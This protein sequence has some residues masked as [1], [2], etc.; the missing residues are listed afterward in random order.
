MEQLRDRVSTMEV[1]LETLR[2]R[3]TQV[4]DLRDAHGLREGQRALIARLTE[5]EE[6]A[7]VHTLREFVTKILRL[8]SL[9]CG[10]QGGIVGEAVRACNRRL[11]NHKAMMDDFYARI[12]IQDW[13]H[14]LSEQETKKT[15][16]SLLLGLMVTTPMLRINQEWR[17]VHLVGVESGARRNSADFRDQCLDH[18]HHHHHKYKVR[19][20]Q[21]H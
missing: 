13:Y 5:I 8:E 1:N 17:I 20:R 3:L 10:E 12:R 15:H 6:C 18:H 14:D 9:V 21:Q 19:M 16:N 7:S 11:D 2:T 4:A